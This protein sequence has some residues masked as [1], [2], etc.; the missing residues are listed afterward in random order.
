MSKQQVIA[1]LG[2]EREKLISGEEQ[3]RVLIRALGLEVEVI[4]VLAVHLTAG[5]KSN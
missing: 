4:L 2:I 5:D 1:Q 3:R